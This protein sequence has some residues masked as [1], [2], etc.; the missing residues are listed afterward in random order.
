MNNKNHQNVPQQQR[1]VSQKEVGEKYPEKMKY[2]FTKA[3]WIFFVFLLVI[4]FTIFITSFKK[5]PEDKA[6]PVIYRHYSEVVKEAE[7]EPKDITSYKYRANIPKIV[8]EDIDQMLEMD[9]EEACVVYNNDQGGKIIIE[10]S[11]GSEKGY[12]IRF[13]QEFCKGYTYS[14]VEDAELESNISFY[15]SQDGLVIY[16]GKMEERTVAKYYMSDREIDYDILYNCYVD[17]YG[18]N[19]TYVN[20]DNIRASSSYSTLIRQGTEFCFYY[21][22]KK[23]YTTRFEGGEISDWSYHYVTTTSRDCYNVYYSNNPHDYWIKFC[24]V[25]QNVDRVLETEQITIMDQDANEMH[26]PIFKIG[27]KKYA[28]IP[29]AIAERA[30]GQRYGRNDESREDKIDFT[31]ELVE[32]SLWKSSK[33]KLKKDSRICDVDGF[34]WRLYYY[35]QGTDRECFLEKRINGLDSGVAELIPEEKVKKFDGKVISS[36]QVKKYINRLKSLYEK[37]TDNEF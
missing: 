29:N 6:D 20:C 10:P 24:K 2:K 17:L 35:F 28:Q 25:A 31:S 1:D 30:Y 37:Y 11:K 15:E 14:L 34:F 19:M 12:K 9:E 8:Q 26:F 32:I 27:N 21:L 33:V 7:K 5:E 16:G 13:Q 4:A 18:T 36:S 3:D 22:G 23:V